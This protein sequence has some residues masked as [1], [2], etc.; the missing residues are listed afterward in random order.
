MMKK[1][2]GLTEVGWHG[3]EKTL[4]APKGQFQAQPPS[5]AQRAWRGLRVGVQL[6]TP[7]LVFM[8]NRARKYQ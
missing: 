4:A 2:Y 3:E 7:V 8:R 1:S 6:E 5:P